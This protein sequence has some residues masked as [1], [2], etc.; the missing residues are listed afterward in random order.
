V[1]VSPFFRLLVDEERL[2]DELFAFVSDPSP[3][4]NDRP[5][6]QDLHD[7]APE[8]VDVLEAMVIDGANAREYV[9]DYVRAVLTAPTLLDSR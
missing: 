1:P 7:F 2:A 3:A 6:M 8:M 5:V 4:R 9:A